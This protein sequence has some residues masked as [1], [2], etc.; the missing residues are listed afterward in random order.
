MTLCNKF[1][2]RETFVPI[3]SVSALD[4]NIHIGNFTA[5]LIDAAKRGSC[6]FTFRDI[7]QFEICLGTS[8]KGIQC[9]TQAA[10]PDPVETTEGAVRII[11]KWA[12]SNPDCSVLD[13][14]K[15]VKHALGIDESHP[16]I[17]K[18]ITFLND[19]GKFFLH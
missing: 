4:T 8:Y 16:H 13:L 14:V 1:V 7:I 2:L 17:Q 19:L 15:A 11:N 6:S 3:C 5:L 10:I 9:Q 12:H 18:M